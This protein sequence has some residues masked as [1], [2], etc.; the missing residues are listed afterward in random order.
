VDLDQV[1]DAGA[2]RRP[3]A[4]DQ[5]WDAQAESRL[6][7]WL[8]TLNLLAV[9]NEL[10][11]LAYQR[12]YNTGLVMV[13]IL[14][15]VVGGG[16]L[17][18]ITAWDSTA[19]AS[20]SKGVTIATF[21]CSLALGVVAGLMSTMELKGKYT[22]YARRATAFDKLASDIDVELTLQRSERKPKRDV[23]DA[24]PERV[25]YLQE[26]VDPLPLKFRRKVGMEA[27]RPSM[28]SSAARTPPPSPVPTDNVQDSPTA[29]ATAPKL[30]LPVR[31]NMSNDACCIL[32][33][34]MWGVADKDGPV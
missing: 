22:A 33:Q 8:K 13:T 24:V 28:M 30:A 27:V 10:A 31:T 17:Q 11:A 19:H 1:S 29:R 25:A 20:A 21:V 6:R 18:G 2:R 32:S 9:S 14:T 5:G 23:L 4:T 26:L 3:T 12:W 16:S 15:V 34:S 7:A